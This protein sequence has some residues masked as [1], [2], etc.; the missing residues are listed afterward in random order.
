MS[1]TKIIDYPLLLTV[2]NQ[3]S[4]KF[5]KTHRRWC[6]IITK[7]FQSIYSINS[8]TIAIRVGGRAEAQNGVYIIKEEEEKKYWDEGT[9]LTRT[10][11][12]AFI[13]MSNKSE[14]THSSTRN[15]QDVR[16]DKLKQMQRAYKVYTREMKQQQ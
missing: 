15:P 14:M 9:K 2:A 13:R 4:E 12:H 10:H 16:L 1:V 11:M 3:G 7:I 8:V 5:M 6:K